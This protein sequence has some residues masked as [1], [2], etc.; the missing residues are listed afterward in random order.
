MPKER[1]E[2]GQYVETAT[3]DAVLGVF[4]DVRGPI[5]TSADVADALGCSRDT[6]RRKLA[7]LHREDRIDRRETAGRVVWWV[8][9]AVGEERAPASTLEGITGLLDSEEA[10][11]FDERTTAFREEV[12]REIMGEN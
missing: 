12:D 9:D 7:A 10:D 6:A 1:G 11:R 2:T 4:E 5:V 8:P 3:L